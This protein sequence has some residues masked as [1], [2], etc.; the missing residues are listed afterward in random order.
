MI[1]EETYTELVRQNLSMLE[2][3]LDQFNPYAAQFIDKKAIVDRIS[4]WR[5]YVSHKYFQKDQPKP[6]PPASNPPIPWLHSQ[7]QGLTTPLAKDIALC[8]AP[9]VESS[10]MTEHA[11]RRISQRLNMILHY[12]T[13]EDAKADREAAYKRNVLDKLTLK[14]KAAYELQRRHK[15]EA[16]ERAPTPEQLEKSAKDYMEKK[17]RQRK[18]ARERREAAKKKTDDAYE[19]ETRRLKKSGNKA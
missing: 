18:E 8:I 11:A 13:D 2:N 5:W 19:A 7:L 15:Q 9:V 10:L 6:E 12:V 17:D 1:T 16:A 4:T 3:H 14:E